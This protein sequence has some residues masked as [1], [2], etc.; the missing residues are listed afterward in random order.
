MHATEL[1]RLAMRERPE[2][3]PIM[4]QNW[5]NLLFMH[6]PIDVATIRPLIPEPL[7]IDTFQEQAWIGITPFAM[8]G[9]RF[10]ALPAV[11]GLD[12]FL[13]LNVRTYVH[14]NGI[15]GVWFFSLDA[16]KLIPSVAARILFDLPYFKAE[17][18]FTDSDTEF[19]FRSRRAVSPRARFRA[20]WQP[21]K[22]LGET[23]P[24][25]LEFF[26]VER[27][28]LFAGTSDRLSTA[29]IYHRPWLLNEAA[30]L[31]HESTMI[32][33]LG[34]PEPSGAPLVHFSLSRNVEVWAPQKL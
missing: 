2:G 3:S 6:W 1:D 7:E 32:E 4:Y 21:G 15:P 22:P 24:E 8:N 29:R 27:Y 34:I 20:R 10:V 13:E 9:V 14:H 18:Q 28:A 30:V 33:C 26:L 25:S 17:M 23:I 11:P 12:S 31:S 19:Q 16:S 5:D